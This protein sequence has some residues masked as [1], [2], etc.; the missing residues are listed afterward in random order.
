MAHKMQALLFDESIA[1]HH[2]I[3]V[4]IDNDQSMT[5]PSDDDD[6]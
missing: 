1:D 3:I 4:H 2:I 5:S 6:R